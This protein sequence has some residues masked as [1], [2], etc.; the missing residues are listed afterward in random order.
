MQQRWTKR[1]GTKCFKCW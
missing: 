1:Y